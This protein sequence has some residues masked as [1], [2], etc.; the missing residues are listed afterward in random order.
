MNPLL[1]WFV[2]HKWCQLALKDGF[3]LVVQ[4]EVKIFGLFQL[5]Y[6]DLDPWSDE[7]EDV[8]LSFLK[9]IYAGIDTKP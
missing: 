2:T 9:C 3:S 4:R 7:E 1:G 8:L 5:Q 6:I